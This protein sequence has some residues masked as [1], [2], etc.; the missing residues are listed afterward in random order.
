[1]LLQTR[2]FEQWLR[3]WLASERG[4]D[5]MVR[6]LLTSNSAVARDRFGPGNTAALFFIAKENKPEELAAAASRIFLGVNLGCAQ[7]HNHPFA[8]WKK[9]QFWS[10]AAFF[11]DLQ[12]PGA[13]RE[14][15]RERGRPAIGQLTIP[16][17]DKVVKA[18][19]LDGKEAS[20]RS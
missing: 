17:T 5:T 1:P 16:G 13:R 19:Y 3:T 6:D 9:D 18:R 15:G 2:G 11:S 10:F 4:Y 14:P 7:C 20:L 12:G 8:S